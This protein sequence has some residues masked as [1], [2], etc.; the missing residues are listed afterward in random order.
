MG[1]INSFIKL[2]TVLLFII[3]P[4]VHSQEEQNFSGPLK[5]GRFE[6][7]AEYTYIIKDT[8]TILEGAFAMQRSNLNALLSNSDDFFSFAGRFENGYPEG[9]WKFQFGEFQSE[10]ETEVVGYQY[11]VKVSGTQ[12]EAMGN[13]AK[14]KPNGIWTYVVKKIE[15][16]EVSSTLFSSMLEFEKGVPQK[17]FRIENE[18]NSLVG[19]FLRSGLAHDVWTLYSDESSSELE[20]WYFNDGFLQKIEI[21]LADDVIS[22]DYAPSSGLV[23]T[24]DLEERY[25]QLLRINQQVTDTTA[26]FNRGIGQLLTQNLG[27]YKELDTILSHLGNSEFMPGFKVRVA[28]FPLDSVQKKQLQSIAAQYEVAIKTSQSLLENT[29]LNILR[30][31]DEEAQFL[32]ALVSKISQD[33]LHPIGKTVDYQNQGILEFISE[34]TLFRNIFPEGIP[35]KTISVVIE[36]RTRAFEESG[37]NKVDFSGNNIEKL[38]QLSEYATSSL[39]SI[40]RKLEEKL[41]KESKQQ[42]LIALEEQMIAHT[43]HIGQVIDSVKQGLPRAEKAALQRI[44]ELTDA[45]LEA[46][47]SIK[48]TKSKI[49]FG[50]QVLQCLEQLDGLANTVSMLPEQR[51]TLAEKYKDDVWNPFMATIMSEE[52]KKRITMAYKNVLVPHVLSQ[53]ESDLSCENAGDLQE[54][55]NGSYERMLEMRDENTSKLERKLR[56]EQDPQVVLQLFNLKSSEN[57]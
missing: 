34:E 14:G 50:Q 46:Y 49:D 11:R 40:A 2:F 54:L 55:L 37:A 25:I 16:S 41:L 51:K 36:N 24:I 13:I 52:V 35:S 28:H 1:H 56:K 31:S 26:I 18:H 21:H 30:R 5:L 33:F 32:Y 44:Q 53:V 48:D 45:Q 15:N 6:G 7:Q 10:S 4:L 19:R 39:E 42:E 43:N 29:Q 27:Y 47:A 8:D 12:H 23:K 3:G 22:I 38:Q 9:N 20:S 17:S 57:H